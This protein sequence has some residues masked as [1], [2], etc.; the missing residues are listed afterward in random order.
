M[1]TPGDIISYLE[2]CTEEQVNLQRGMNFHLRGKSNVILMSIRKGAPYADKIENN[3]K[4]LIYEGHDIPQ[5]KGGP[6]PKL[7]D[8]PYSNPNGTLTQNGLF[9]EA[10][11]KFKKNFFGPELVKVYEKIKAGIWVYNGIFRLVDAW[12]E[13]SKHRK[14]FK[15]RLESTNE[16][17]AL[18][19]T[20]TKD[21]EHN[22]LIP[23]SVKLEV[24]KRDKGSCTKCGSKDNLH[25]DHIIPY[26]KGG[27]SL[28]AK[29]IQL[30]CVR[31]NLEK[32]DTIE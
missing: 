12:Q 10:A 24:W 11:K 19:N 31:H 17:H 15:F 13:K 16:D 29:N 4:T 7:I 9:F 23:T 32:K 30:L 5:K 6:N 22:R 2:M 8:Q 14:V 25:F 20:M 21:I 26:S 3:G 18:K 27:S 28:I 1:F